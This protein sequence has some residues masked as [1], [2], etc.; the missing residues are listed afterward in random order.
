DH[1]VWIHNKVM[2]GTHTFVTASLTNNS[3]AKDA[4]AFKDYSLTIPDYL[5]FAVEKA[6]K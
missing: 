4:I 3:P 6:A 1:K 5:D 2:A